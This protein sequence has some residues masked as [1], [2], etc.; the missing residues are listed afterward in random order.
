VRATKVL[1]RNEPGPIAA[2]L[3]E[4]PL[5]LRLVPQ[6]IPLLAG[7]G[8][9]PD[10]L[11]ALRGVATRIV[12]QVADTFLDPAT[13]LRVRRWLPGL[14]VSS[15]SQRAF[16][17]LLGGLNDPHYEVRDRCA[18]ALS[19]MLAGSAALPG[20]ASADR[21]RTA[22]YSQHCRRACPTNGFRLP[23]ASLT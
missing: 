19:R 6:V 8:L 22:G 13:P 14:L 11:R 23:F 16:D 1:S 9:R 3:A 21:P 17:G 18:R 5:D 15:G 2:L 4:E 7:D 10:A 12:G 20:P